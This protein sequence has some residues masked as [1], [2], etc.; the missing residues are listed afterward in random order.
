[1]IDLIIY[2]VS[3]LF[4]LGIGFVLGNERYLSYYTKA[5]K[6]IEKVNGALADDTITVDEIRDIVSDYLN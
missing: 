4:S 5:K 3:V 6:T 2:G 1:M